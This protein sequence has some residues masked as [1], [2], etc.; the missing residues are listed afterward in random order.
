MTG[1]DEHV[2]VIGSGQA[3]IGVAESL[4]S[5]GFD[6]RISVFGAERHPPYHRPPLSKEWLSGR[7]EADQLTLRAPAALARKRIDWSPG[8]S[9][10]R[11]DLAARRVVL[12]DGTAVAFSGL[13]F[14]TGAR[15]RR[16]GLP[17]DDAEGVLALR[18]RDDAE[19][20]ARALDGCLSTGRPLVVV[21]GG[22]VGL[23]VAATA[24]SRGV[25]V[26]VLE[27]LPRLMARSV[28]VT[29][30]DWY[31]DLHRRHGVTV[32][33]GARV[34]DLVIGAGDVVTAG[35]VSGVRLEDGTVLP[36]GAV[37]VGVGAQPED[38]L[39]AAAGL[40]CAGGI[41][42]DACG[43]TAV[44][45]VVAAGDCT[46]TR[47]ADGTLRRLESVQSAVEQGKAAA[48]A[49]LGQDRPFTAAPWF[50]SAQYDTKLEFVGLAPDADTEVVRGDPSSG[51]FS[52][53]RYAGERLRAVDSVN[54]TADH[55]AAR[56]MLDAGR[57]PSPAQAAD[58]EF[59]LAD[60]LT[61]QSS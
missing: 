58:P 35:A 40:E 4:R 47:L 1:T 57:R 2:V 34:A 61:D 24:R 3:G 42:V 22:F 48:A 32:R 8:T 43:R 20:I 13:A 33:L 17:G 45:E 7:I 6:G 23:E 36:A 46:V 41:V 29:V 12:A 39:A 52:V 11:V 37:V 44:P 49:L 31:A 53:F 28:S 59:D 54:A 21:G 55:R 16:L 50:W 18:T 25:A 10:A 19:A 30:S 15:P 51:S 38:R 5:L 14:A 26:T 27:G 60:V 9:V 56:T